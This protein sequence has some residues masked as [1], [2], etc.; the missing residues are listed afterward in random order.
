MFTWIWVYMDWSRH[1]GCKNIFVALKQRL[2]DIHLQEW[3]SSILNN[4]RLETYSQ[5]KSLLNMEL[6]LTVVS[7]VR[8][9]VSLARLRCSSHGLEIEKG[10]HKNIHRTHRYCNYCLRHG[11]AIVENEYHFIM[12]CPLYDDLRDKYFSK[13]GRFSFIFL[14]SNNNPLT[15]NSLAAFVY[16]AFSRRDENV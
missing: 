16:H 9:K 11:E 12:E 10:R 7:N 1:R 8:Y 13:L 3:M 4:R 2:K 15:L 5:F 14:M 6:Y